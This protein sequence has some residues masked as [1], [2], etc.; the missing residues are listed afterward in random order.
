MLLAAQ[1]SGGNGKSCVFLKRRGQKC[2]NKAFQMRKRI[3]HKMHP[4]NKKFVWVFAWARPFYSPAE[5][6]R[7]WW[8]RRR[9]DKNDQ[10]EK[11]PNR[12]AAGCSCK[13]QRDGS[14]PRKP[15]EEGSS[16]Q[17]PAAL[18]R[19]RTGSRPQHREK[20]ESQLVHKAFARNK[21]QKDGL[22]CKKVCIE[23]VD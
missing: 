1:G 14:R 7:S 16:A 2:Y 21:N 17:G 18:D 15:R 3:L 11:L 5:I 13:S 22:I 12:K 19:E 4:A 23:N 9:K 8:R 20:E 10:K 6:V